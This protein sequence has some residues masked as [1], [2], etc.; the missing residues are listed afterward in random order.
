[1]GGPIA[2]KMGVSK[3]FI[4]RILFAGMP[5]ACEMCALEIL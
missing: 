5:T 1:M 2:C 4:V 3:I